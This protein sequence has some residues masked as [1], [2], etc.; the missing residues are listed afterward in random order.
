MTSL[1]RPFS[2]FIP[3]AEY[4]PRVVGPPSSMLSRDQKKASRNDELSFRHVVGR[5]ASADRVEAKNWLRHCIDLGALQAVESALIVHRLERDDFTATG[6]LADVS[7][8]A[9]DAGRIKRH[10]VTIPKTQRK[11]LEYMQ[12][13]RIFGNPVALAHRTYAEFATSLQGH[14]QHTADVTFQSVDGTQHSLW[15]VGG[16]EAQSMCDSFNDV[17]YITDGH[18]RLAAASALA[19]AE[20]WSS[21]HL[22]AAL[23]AEAELTVGSFARAVDD[24]D[25]VAS[26]VLVSLHERFD[27]VEVE[28][29]IARPKCPHQMGVRI[30]GRSFLLT[31]PPALIPTKIYDRLD[32]NLLQDLVL[33]P[34]FGITNARTDERL[35]FVADTSDAHDVDSC[36]AWF[37]PY[38]T[39]VPDVMLVA[40]A[41]SAMP[42]KSTYFMPKVPSGLAIRPVDSG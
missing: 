12:S 11:M 3:S 41:G 4:A 34:L 8:A 40:D 31:I 22:P 5:G 20:A 28:D 18:H 13:T 7:V 21:P 25:V 33:E 1:L 17:L 29:R 9:Y 30:G 37:L 16:D 15:V 35:R 27:L 39:S 19:E 23:Y 6:F 38:P 26:A 10:E 2:G 36:L 42:P 32:V 14:S 24:G